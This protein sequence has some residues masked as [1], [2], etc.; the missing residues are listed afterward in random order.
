[1]PVNFFKNPTV[2]FPV[3]ENPCSSLIED[4]KSV[5]E[6]HGVD[7]GD[8]R[9]IAL[10]YDLLRRAHRH[11]PLMDDMNDRNMLNCFKTAIKHIAS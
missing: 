6:N 8:I 7:M 10:S 5:F 3:F 1:M 4:Y 9:Q 11:N 2:E